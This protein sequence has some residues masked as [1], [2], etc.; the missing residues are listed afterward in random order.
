MTHIIT[1]SKLTELLQYNLMGLL[2]LLQLWNSCTILALALDSEIMD[3]FLWPKIEL[4][5]FYTTV[6]KITIIAL[7][8]D[9]NIF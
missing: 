1:S 3:I 8:L 7:A 5:I 4:K 9:L 6:D 2:R